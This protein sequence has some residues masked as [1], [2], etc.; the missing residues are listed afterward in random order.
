MASDSEQ[1]LSS[2]EQW[3]K[4]KAEEK[5]AKNRAYYEKNQKQLIRKNS[6]VRLESDFEEDYG[7]FFSCG[8]NVLLATFSSEKT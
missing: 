6:V 8:Q 4:K 2:R 3:R 1:K 7:S 5:K